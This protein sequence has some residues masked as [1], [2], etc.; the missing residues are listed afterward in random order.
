VLAN[1]PL[2]FA[3]VI[4]V[5]TLEARLNAAFVPQMPRQVPFPTKDA[6]TV[7]IWAQE[8][9]ATVIIAENSERSINI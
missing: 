6:T 9:N 3:V 2:E 5:G 8:F 4:A 1:V 7:T